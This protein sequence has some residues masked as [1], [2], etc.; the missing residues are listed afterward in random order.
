M[1]PWQRLRRALESLDPAP[2]DA[3]RGRVG[4]ALALLSDP[5][6][7]DLEI[8]FTRRRDDLSHHPGQVSFP[9]GRVDT[10]ES[11][12]DAAL[13]EAVEEVAVDPDTV[14]LIGALPAGYIPPSRFWFQ[15]VVGRWHAPHRLVPAEA[16]VAE[17]LTARLSR[18]RDAETWRVV[19]LSARGVSWAWQLDEHHLLWGATA[20]ATSELLAILDPGWHRGLEPAALAPER[21]ARPW[22]PARYHVPRPGPARLPGVEEVPLPAASPE[23]GGDL[24]AGAV[25]AAGAAVADAVGRLG[26][27]RVLVL[28]GAG[29]DGAVGLAT[30]RVLGGGGHD[31]EVVLSAPPDT[32]RAPARRELDA[33]EASVAGRRLPPADVLVDALVGRGLTGPLERSALEV[34]LAMRHHVAPV[35]SVDLPTGIDPADGLVGDCVAADVTVAIGGLS[36]GLLGPG[37]GP[38][39][40]DLY[41]APLDRPLVRMVP[42]ADGSRWRE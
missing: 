11:V 17:V 28:A 35:V 32:M 25:R 3:A 42:G 26:V 30:A 10:G 4:A 33:L 12:A 21:E 38:F 14:E 6:D 16:E 9:G 19:R 36:T 39:V 34:V 37:L 2:V 31:V 27:H 29:G 20:M 1:D 13:R 22:V 8:V 7:G 24:S 40:G 41:L 15:V 18:L 23:P 5:G